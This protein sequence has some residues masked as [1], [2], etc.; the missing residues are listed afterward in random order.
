MKTEKIMNFNLFKVFL[1]VLGLF[2]LFNV[3]PP[4]SEASNVT[5]LS[6]DSDIQM[7]LAG[8]IVLGGLDKRILR[9]VDVDDSNIFFTKGIDKSKFTLTDAEGT[10]KIYDL[11]VEGLEYTDYDKLTPV[12]EITVIN[13]KAM[14]TPVVLNYNSVITTLSMDSDIQMQLN[15]EVIKGE[16]NGKILRFVDVNDS[17]MFYTKD[18]NESKIKLINGTYKVYD[19]TVQGLDYTDY[20]K[21]TPVGEITVSNGTTTTA[22]AILNFKKKYAILVVAGQSNA[23][24]YDESPVDANEELYQQNM[25]IKQLGLRGENNLKIIPLTYSAENF[26]DMTDFSNASSEGRFGTKGIHLPLGHLILPH[27]PEDYELLVI[28]A[29]YGGTGFTTTASYGE[30]DEE[31]KKPADLSIGLKW[32]VE[33]AFYKSM[34]DRVQYVL[35]M[36]EDNYYIGTVWIQGEHDSMNAK[37]AQ[38]HL[39]LFEAMTQNFFDYFN[40][41]YADRVKGG[42][43][44]K[45]QWFNVETVPYWNSTY[46]NAAVIWDNYREWSPSTYV[47]IE[48]G[49][50]SSEYTNETNGTGLTSSI[51][52][53]HYGNNAYADLVAP[54]VF[55]KMLEVGVIE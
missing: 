41:N 34:R 9:M 8:E 27:I 52:G 11:T 30:Y 44:S 28:P 16:L 54:A 5:Y 3:H 17:N 53:S 25:R 7:K 20:D 35:D 13:G 55:E 32:G 22:P 39:P 45:E 1:L 19:L 24:G 14:T 47:D 50:N 36:N 46:E 33:S 29:A 40:E 23:V 31:N 37:Q 51:R 18:I 21:L 12:G 42:V 10:Y 26:Q 48:F 15:G 43:W 6:M 49:N 2:V 38:Q 4:K